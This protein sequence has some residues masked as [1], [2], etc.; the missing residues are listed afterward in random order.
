[1]LKINLKL[2]KNYFNKINLKKRINKIK[3]Y[4]YC[5]LFFLLI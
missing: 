5:L 2:F 3:I 4:Q 1:M